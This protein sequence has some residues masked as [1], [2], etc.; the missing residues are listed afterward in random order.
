MSIH[1]NVHNENNVTEALCRANFKYPGCH[2]LHIFKKQGFT[3]LMWMHLKRWYLKS[4]SSRKDLESHISPV[5][6]PWTNGKLCTSKGFD[7]APSLLTAT[8]KSSSCKI[9]WNKIF[10]RFFYKIIYTEFYLLIF[11]TVFLSTRIFMYFGIW[12]ADSFC[13][14][15]FIYLCFNFLYF[16]SSVLA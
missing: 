4:G 5:V 11:F 16:C 13:D 1:T 2:K 14:G 3:S 8:N 6:T 7:T 15:V 10:V 12:Y 9:K